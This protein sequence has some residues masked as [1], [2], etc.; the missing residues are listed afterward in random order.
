MPKVASG[1][2]RKI[3]PEREQRRRRDK[4]PNDV[5]PMPS[6]PRHQLMID[7]WGAKALSEEHREKR[8][9]DA[10][11]DWRAQDHANSGHRR[12]SPDGASD[13]RTR[14]VIIRRRLNIVGGRT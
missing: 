1:D 13:V 7:S 5:S 12:R 8:R 3:V 2:I 4:A 6:A 9:R 14:A 11:G 10:G